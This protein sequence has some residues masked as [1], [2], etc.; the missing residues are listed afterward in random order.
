M[1]KHFFYAIVSL[2][3]CLAGLTGCDN[4]ISYQT[5]YTYSWSVDGPYVPSNADKLE[6]YLIEL[7]APADGGKLNNTMVYIQN[8][9]EEECDKEAIQRFNEVVNKIDYNKLKDMNLSLQH[10]YTYRLLNS[11]YTT[12]AEW[13]YP[14]EHAAIDTVVTHSL[15]SIRIAFGAD[16]PKYCD[17][18]LL[19]NGKVVKTLAEGD[20]IYE[21]D[22]E[23]TK[24][25]QDMLYSS[26]FTKKVTPTDTIGLHLGA[27]YYYLLTNRNAANEIVSSSEVYAAEKGVAWGAYTIGV[28]STKLDSWLERY[29]NQSI[30]LFHIDG[31]NT[32]HQ[33][34]AE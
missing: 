21:D 29:G 31:K 28:P 26:H 3:L 13:T 23:V 15:L 7:G 18:E 24:F 5:F 17:A 16:L 6:A 22:F 25:P 1:K 11:H 34:P 33:K 27:R 4:L 9:S 12:I 2:S 10:T 19:L 14:N 32:V 20:T 30:V 8:V